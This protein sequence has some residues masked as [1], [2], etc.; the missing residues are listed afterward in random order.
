VNR[1]FA[2]I[3]T[4]L[5]LIPSLSCAE[6]QSDIAE[7]TPS[8]TE[9]APET[10]SEDE[11]EEEGRKSGILSKM[12]ENLLIVPIPMSSPTFG[13]GLIL[14]GAY[15]YRQTEDQKDT[16]PASYTG[17]AGGYTSSES[18]FA[19]IMQKN[20]WGGDKWRFSGFAGYLDLNLDLRPGSSEGDGV[21]T[22][23]WL[24]DGSLIQARLLRRIKGDWYFGVTGRYLDISQTIGQEILDEDFNLQSETKAGAIGLNLEYDSRDVAFNP[25]QGQHF[26]LR[27]MTSNPSGSDN[28]SYQSY[29]ARLTSYHSISEPLVLALDIN[30]CAKNGQVPLWDTCR[31]GLRGFSATD[32]LSKQ[33]LYAQAELRWRIHGKWGMVAFGGVGRVDD[34]LGISNKNQTVPSYGLGI[35]F[36]LLESQRINLRIDYARSDKGNDA[37]YLSVSEAF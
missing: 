33:S 25:F 22:V 11:K 9:A 28:G 27:A 17:V 2:F 20:Y 35:R 13:T 1:T 10:D 14:G 24:V 26:E 32:Y 5:Y 37:W 18:W 7:D 21:G 29:S 3:F 4:L 16:Q 34:T 8:V 15:F 31:L 30:G 23:K 6:I 19:G 36:M 12:P